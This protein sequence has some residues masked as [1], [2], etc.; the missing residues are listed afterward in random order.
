MADSKD[1]YSLP[2]IPD[3]LDGDMTAADFVTVLRDIR[4]RGGMHTI[5]RTKKHETFCS[6]ACS[7]GSASARSDRLPL[8]VAVVSRRRQRIEPL[9]VATA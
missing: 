7:P 3:C 9:P 1:P 6:T 2:A 8:L 5:K 4:F